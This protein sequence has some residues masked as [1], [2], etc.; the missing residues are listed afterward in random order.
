MITK[1]NYEVKTLKLNT[2]LRGKAEGS[3]VRVKT[4]K[5]GS[6]LDPYWRRRLKDS[7]IDGCVEI[8]TKTV[9]VKKSKE[10][11]GGK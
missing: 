1:K 4:D 7:K 10:N 5:S 11:K 2:S 8:V 9:K 6:P 3:L